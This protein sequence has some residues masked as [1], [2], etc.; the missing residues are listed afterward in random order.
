MIK[1]LMIV[2]FLSLTACNTSNPSVLSEE[3][4][5][6]GVISSDDLSFYESKA[7]YNVSLGMTR[8]EI[9]D[10]L[11]VPIDTFNFLGM[12]EYSGIK[13]H[14][15]KDNIVNGLVID[16]N[17]ESNNKYSTPRGIKYGESIDSIIK[18]YG[19][20]S[21]TDESNNNTSLTYLLEESSDGFIIRSTVDQIQKRDRAY[22]ISMNIDKVHGMIFIMIADFEYSYNPTR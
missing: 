14:F 9:E 22:T 19:E 11:G 12:N 4:F 21:H 20:P 8:E 13:V 2:I 1:A 7:E 17:T 6:P 3:D 5:K 10:R 16:D 15:N 18:R